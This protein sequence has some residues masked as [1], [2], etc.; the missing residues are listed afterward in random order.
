MSEVKDNEENKDDIENKE[1]FPCG[2][3]DEGD[4]E[5]DELWLSSILESDAG[6]FF[7]ED[8]TSENENE[9]GD[10]NK[11]TDKSEDKGEEDE[12]D[13]EGIGPL[14]LD[15]V[16]SDS[17]NI[18]LNEKQKADKK[19]S[20]PGNLLS[21][22]PQGEG[23]NK[24][25]KRLV[26][27]DAVKVESFAQGESSNFQGTMPPRELMSSKELLASGGFIMSK[28]VMKFN[29]TMTFSTN[30]LMEDVKKKVADNRQQQEAVTPNYVLDMT[31]NSDE[32]D[33]RGE[34]EE[35]V[36]RPEK[37]D[38]EKR[39]NNKKKNIK[40]NIKRDENKAEKVTAEKIDFSA[41][42]QAVKKITGLDQIY[43]AKERAPIKKSETL[44]VKKNK[45]VKK[46]Q[47]MIMDRLSHAKSSDMSMDRESKRTK[48]RS[49]IWL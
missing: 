33:K 12:N 38:C 49:E 5:D 37:S 6:Q 46:T 10:E 13:E 41:K 16:K 7:E 30:N 39:E 11:E 3:Y 25:F 4:E 44:Q 9:Q 43:K 29:E 48:R 45:T 1:L 23:K 20:K 42:R 8:E 2:L 27:N 31:R 17:F 21:A 36:N 14:E 15:N 32:S 35:E 40:E 22:M 19:E 26:M 34:R 24:S 18:R 47:T 28:D